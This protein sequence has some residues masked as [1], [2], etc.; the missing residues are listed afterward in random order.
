[1]FQNVINMLFKIQYFTDKLSTKSSSKVNVFI[2]SSHKNKICRSIGQ[3]THC[4]IAGINITKSW[5]SY[6]EKDMPPLNQSSKYSHS[7]Q[8][9]HTESHWVTVGL[10]LLLSPSYLF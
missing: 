5:F 6:T 2:I 4:P 8:N 1:M 10:S 9:I 3:L 7:L